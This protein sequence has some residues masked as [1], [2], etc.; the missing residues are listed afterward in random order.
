MNIHKNLT[1][2]VD[3]VKEKQKRN[4]C[5]NLNVCAISYN[6]AVLK[7]VCMYEKI[8]RYRSFSRTVDN[9]SVK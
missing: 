4:Y 3:E 2:V 1:H 9:R 7:N 6:F 8:Y 5:L